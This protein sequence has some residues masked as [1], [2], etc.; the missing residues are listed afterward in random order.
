M[1]EEQ[2]ARRIKKS[3]QSLRNHEGPS[4]GPIHKFSE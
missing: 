3:E 1:S 2:K 4:N